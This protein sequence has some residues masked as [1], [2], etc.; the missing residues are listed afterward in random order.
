MQIILT[1]I[2]KFLTKKKTT[3]T[4]M[5]VGHLVQLKNIDRNSFPEDRPDVYVYFV[6]VNGELNRGSLPVNTIG[7]IVEAAEK[8]KMYKVLFGDRLVCVS[9]SY[10]DLL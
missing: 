9:D 2:G 8:S 4:D 1:R 10:L 7:M 3:N 6:E 5:K